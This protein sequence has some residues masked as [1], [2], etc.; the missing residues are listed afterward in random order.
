[1][2]LIFFN[3]KENAAVACI[4]SSLGSEAAGQD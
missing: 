1:M 3:H 4:F 2:E